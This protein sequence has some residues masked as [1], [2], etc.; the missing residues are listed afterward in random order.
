M[1]KEN[2]FEYAKVKGIKINEN[3][4]FNDIFKQITVCTNYLHIACVKF[5]VVEFFPSERAL[6]LSIHHFN[7]LEICEQIYEH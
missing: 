7:K 6:L 2:L 4:S 5:V 1:N 3:D